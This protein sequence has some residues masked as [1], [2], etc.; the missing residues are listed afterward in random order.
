MRLGGHHAAFA[1]S[2]VDQLEALCPGF[3]RLGLSAVP[4][5]SGL[6]TMSDEDC[7]EFGEAARSLGLVIGETGMW[8]NL[9]TTDPARRTERI[10]RVRALLR[11]AALM[12]CRCVITLVGSA[13]PSDDPLAPDALTMSREGAAAFREVVLRILDGLELGATR[14]G[15]EPWVTTFFYGVEEVA[16]FLDAVDHPALGLHLDLV[17]M[18]SR[19]SYFDTAGLAERTFSLLSDRIVGAHLKDLVWDPAH[20]V[21]K[22]DEVLIGDGVID[23]PAYLG[24]LARLD[25]DLACYCEHLATEADYAENFERAHSAAE[26]AGVR[27]L[28]RTPME[29]SSR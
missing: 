7:I 4:A 25:S 23:Y 21:I 11:K 16:E 8:E 12:G 13:H 19:R 14:Y 20:M 2:T 5:P 26:R 10:E 22:W 27:F 1:A 29:E 9:M 6:A 28:P 15:I 3:D 18:V 24:V 17:N